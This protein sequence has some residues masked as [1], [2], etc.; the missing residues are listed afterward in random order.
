MEFEI[1][2]TAIRSYANMIHCDNTSKMIS[3]N[4]PRCS[5]LV[6]FFLFE[7]APTACKCGREFPNVVELYTSLPERV[8]RHFFK[9]ID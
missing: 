2:I 5:I 9:I 1:T 4:C 3:F 6:T 7:E 8:K